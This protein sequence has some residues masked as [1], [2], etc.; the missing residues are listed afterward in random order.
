MCL[1]MPGFW[2]WLNLPKCY[3][4]RYEYDL[5]MVEYDWAI[6]FLNMSGFLIWFVILDSTCLREAHAGRAVWND[7]DVAF[8]KM[9]NMVLWIYLGVYIC[10][11]R[12]LP[13]FWICQGYTRF[14]I[15][16][17][18]LL[19]NAWIC[20][21]ICQKQNLNLLYNLRNI[22]RYLGVFKILSNI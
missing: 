18:M 19:I 6:I 15:H 20:L 7:Q 22:Y 17:S 13:G 2:I 1:N 9:F 14:L 4:Y 21:G 8:V 5:S 11:V 10:F 3:V 16:V 12:N